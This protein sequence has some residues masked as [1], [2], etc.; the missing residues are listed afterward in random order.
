VPDLVSKMKSR[1]DKSEVYLVFNNFQKV[2][3]VGITE[4]DLPQNRYVCLLW[5][6][7]SGE[8]YGLLFEKMEDNDL[9]VAGVWNLIKFDDLG[10]LEQEINDDLQRLQEPEFF[11][12]IS[13]FF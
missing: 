4:Q 8:K 13:L 2:T 3:K 12:D 11:E 10:I 6:R 9:S 7:K 5:T 1:Q